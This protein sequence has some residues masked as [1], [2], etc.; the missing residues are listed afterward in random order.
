MTDKTEYCETCGGGCYEED[1]RWCG[2]C[3]DADICKCE[4]C[5]ENKVG[6]EYNNDTCNAIV[7]CVECRL[8][9]GFKRW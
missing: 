1:A 6:C 3:R 4:E 2:T 5:G 9:D 8:K 7:M